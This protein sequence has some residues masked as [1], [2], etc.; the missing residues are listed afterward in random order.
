MTV[1]VQYIQENPFSAT[2]NDYTCDYIGTG[3]FKVSNTVTVPT[4]ARAVRLQVTGF[5]S[6]DIDWTVFC[7]G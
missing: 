2:F 4:S 5:T 6:G 1:E 3:T 7:N